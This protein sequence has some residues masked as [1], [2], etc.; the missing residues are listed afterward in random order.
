[1]LHKHPS[2]HTPLQHQPP[3]S[4]TWRILPRDAR[5]GTRRHTRQHFHIPHLLFTPRP[6]II[7]DNFTVEPFSGREIFIKCRFR[8]KLRNLV[9]KG[10]RLLVR[11]VKARVSGKYRMQIKCRR[12][13]KRRG[14]GK[15]APDSVFLTLS[16]LCRIKKLTSD[17]EKCSLCFGSGP[18]FRL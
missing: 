10:R 2:K 3:V 18:R 9:P 11:A 14:E 8:Q 1:M 16:V 4:K 12:K 7:K 13:Q 17:F 6:F 5:P 15:M